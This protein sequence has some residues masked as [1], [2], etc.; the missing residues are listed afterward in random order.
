MIKFAA[1][2][3]LLILSS[4]ANPNNIGCGVGFDGNWE[5]TQVTPV[6]EGSL[7]MIVKNEYEF[8]KEKGSRS[9][10]TDESKKLLL[11]VPY[12]KISRDNFYRGTL[13]S[14]F[15]QQF[16]FAKDSDHAY[17]LEDYT[18]LICTG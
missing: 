5:P 13:G 2:C 3:S 12:P 7:V 14:C 17:K 9:W 1:L 4:C 8:F 16:I 6:L 11:C 15:T 18:D 10:Y